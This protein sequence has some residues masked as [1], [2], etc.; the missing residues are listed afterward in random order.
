[1]DR[2][3][4]ATPMNSVYAINPWHTPWCIGLDALRGY[5]G[6]C[7]GRGGAEGIL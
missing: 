2:A 6:A 5:L 4:I 1:V 3:V 7:P